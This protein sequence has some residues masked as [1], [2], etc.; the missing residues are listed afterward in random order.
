MATEIT[1]IVRD[2]SDPDNRIDSVG[3]SGWSK[4]EDT[5]IAEIEN[6][7][8]TYFVDVGG[9]QVQVEVAEREGRKYL[10]TDSDQTTE[11]NLLSLPDCP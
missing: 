11:N 2:G 8:E 10:R 1:C 9:N 3:G 5:V 6:G 4:P 7:S